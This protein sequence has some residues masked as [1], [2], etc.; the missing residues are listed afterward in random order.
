MILSSTAVICAAPATWPEIMSERLILFSIRP[1]NGAPLA[2][3]T[4]M[5]TMQPASFVREPEDVACDADDG[6]MMWRLWWSDIETLLACEKL[7]LRTGPPGNACDISSLQF[8]PKDGRSPSA[9]ISTSGLLR[10]RGVFTTEEFAEP[11]TCCAAASSLA[12][13][14]EMAELFL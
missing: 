7:G 2:V 1:A 8:F 11:E 6:R 5:S 13:A 3:G 12:S 10:R 14:R 9:S 4:D